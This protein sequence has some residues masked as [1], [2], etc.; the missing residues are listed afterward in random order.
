MARRLRSGL[1]YVSALPVAGLRA[2][3]DRLARD[4]R[5]PNTAYHAL[6][7]DDEVG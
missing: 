2:D 5:E 6:I 7:P 3:A 4:I 1:P